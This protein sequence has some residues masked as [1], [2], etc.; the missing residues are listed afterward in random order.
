L[1]L[2]A[3][4]TSQAQAVSADPAVG[5]PSLRDMQG[6]DASANTVSNQPVML[7]VPIRN[8]NFNNS[9]P[10]G[11][12]RVTIGLGSRLQIDPGFNV[13]TARLS[14][15]FSWTSSF[16]GGQ[17]VIVGNQIQA[18]PP[19]FL[20]STQFRVSGNAIG[21]STITANIAPV[22]NAVDDQDPQN[23]NSS[24]QYTVYALNIMP[25]KLTNF[26]VVRS[27]CNIDVDFTIAEQTNVNRYVVEVSKNGADFETLGNVSA[28]ATNARY[29]SRYAITDAIKAASIYVRLKTVDNDGKFEYSAVRRIAGT[30]EARKSLVLSVYPNPVN[31]GRTITITSKEDN[32]DGKYNVSLIDANGRTL[33]VREM[34]LNSVANFKFDLGAISSGQYLIRVATTDETESAVV[35]FQ[36]H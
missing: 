25:S 16:T 35:R 33:Q 22:S 36:K 32:F 15:Y 31:V 14:Q 17:I 5:A 26:T 2:A 7:T 19:F 8:L 1:F 12:V 10:N 27:G 24:L 29:N 28:R 13:A 21:T 30:C 20:D 18:I 4:L 9:I 3:S 34:Q 6:A 23:N 11:S